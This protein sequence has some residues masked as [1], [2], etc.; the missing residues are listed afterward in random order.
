MKSVAEFVAA[1]SLRDRIALAAVRRELSF[2]V[3]D[4]VETRNGIGV[5][6]VVDNSSY[7]ITMLDILLTEGN[8]KGER[9]YV[10]ES[11]V[12]KA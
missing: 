10:P 1:S 7:S 12:V 8:D 3:G 2:K 5:V 9:I 6:K 11:S 4:K